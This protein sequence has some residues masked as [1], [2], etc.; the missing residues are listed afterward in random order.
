[1]GSLT[2][3]TGLAA[4]NVKELLARLHVW[5]ALHRWLCRRS[6]WRIQMTRQTTVEESASKTLARPL[7]SRHLVM[8]SESHQRATMGRGEEAR[9][10]WR[11]Q[12]AS[13]SPAAILRLAWIV[14]QMLAVKLDC[15]A[16]HL[17]TRLITVL[18]VCGDP[19]RLLAL[20]PVTAG[21]EA[22][23][24]HLVCWT[25]LTIRR[26]ARASAGVLRCEGPILHLVL[27][28]AGRYDDWRVNGHW[29]SF[30]GVSWD[31]SESLFWLGL[32]CHAV[33]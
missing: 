8:A 29:Q 12:L 24:A 3:Y 11:R 26:G 13:E 31:R 9:P 18:Q 10:S 17:K 6:L 4:S 5:A 1:M 20:F 22:L 25:A 2:R 32:T 30:Y 33:G 21:R 15:R 28:A 27:D 16:D 14:H 7:L 23:S 19:S